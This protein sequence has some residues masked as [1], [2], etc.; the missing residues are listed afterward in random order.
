MIFI[1][2]TSIFCIVLLLCSCNALKVC[3][4]EEFMQG[5]LADGVARISVQPMSMIVNELQ[6]PDNEKGFFG[7]H[8]TLKIIKDEEN[9]GKGKAVITV[10]NV[11]L[12]HNKKKVYQDCK[13]EKAYWSGEAFINEANLEIHGYLTNNQKYPIVPEPN[14]TII[15]VDAKA[16]DLK[17]TFETREE[18]IKITGDLSYKVIPRLANSN[19]T[20][21]RTAPTYNTR[22]ADIKLNLDT[23]LKAPDIKINIP[24]KSSDYYIQIGEGENGESN[25]IAGKIEIFDQPAREVPYDKKG[26]DPDY[27]YHAFMQTYNCHEEIAG[28]VSYEHTPFE[29]VMTPLHAG[30]SSLIFGEIAKKL[31]DNHTCG[32]A[33]PE[34][35]VNASFPNKSAGSIDSV[36]LQASNCPLK[37]DNHESKPNRFGEHFILHGEANV[38][39]ATQILTGLITYN[40]D[41]HKTSVDEYQ[42]LLK[43]DPIKA[44]KTAPALKPVMPNTADNFVKIDIQTDKLNLTV[45][46]ICHANK[47]VTDDPRHCSKNPKWKTDENKDFVFALNTKENSLISAELSPILAKDNNR[48]S[49]T[50]NL[51]VKPTSRS[52]IKLT[53]NNIYAS[54]TKGND[55]NDKKRFDFLLNGDLKIFSGY[56]ADDLENKIISNNFTVGKKVLSLT[57]GIKLDPKYERQKFKDSYLLGKKINEVNNEQCSNLE[58][59]L[60]V[61][62]ARMLVLNAGAL[63]AYS[64]NQVKKHIKSNIEDCLTIP[65]KTKNSIDSEEFICSTDNKN[66]S[67]VKDLTLENE[68]TFENLNFK[69]KSFAK[70]SYNGKEDINFKKHDG[71]IN[72]GI[73]YF[74]L[75]KNT[76]NEKNYFR[77]KPTKNNSVDFDLSFNIANFMVEKISPDDKSPM[78]KIDAGQFNIK[79]NPLMALNKKNEDKLYNIQT[80]AVIFKNIEVKNTKASFLYNNMVINLFIHDALLR[81]KNEI[82]DGSG[83]YVLGKINYN[84]INDSSLNHDPDKGVKTIIK[85]A[86]LVPSY[87]EKKQEILGE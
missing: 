49:T 5:T 25:K 37:F 59:N 81:A 17:I 46:P 83:N 71:I 34:T 15:K 68:F 36:L 50:Y 51:C 54:F 63:V 70:M 80:K 47:G 42:N 21:M 87:K 31:E 48:Y 39:K 7:P 69:D 10:K 40:K 4:A 66:L 56:Y 33:A 62:I 41:G 75:A 22:F 35:L 82:S 3:V 53:Y 32:F 20:N 26:M 64:G 11:Y 86:E 44:K 45:T 9:Y 6:K 61:Q 30:M 58:E 52:E 23:K 24:I 16:K 55:E 2:Y 76:L 79:A 72:K 8:A 73:N 65:I 12:R 18:S 13:G 14:G 28:K 84:I 1:K 43:E 74:N 57:S 38:K 60:K 78:L 19:K 77:I 27:N 85:H 67:D 29:E